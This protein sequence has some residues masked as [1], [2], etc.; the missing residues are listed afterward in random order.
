[1]KTSVLFLLFSFF[2]SIS[3]L[4]QDEFF[5]DEPAP[6]SLTT[7]VMEGDASFSNANSEFQITAS[8]GAVIRYDSGFDIPAG[9]T[10]RF[11]QPSVDATVINE[12]IQQTPSQIEGNILA[13]GKVVLLNSSGIV[14]GKDSV[15][16]WANCMRSG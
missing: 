8:D 7:K 2:C 15:V 16:R 6:F 3:A 10:V 5:D 4:A 1:M 11:I 12:I 13:N 14:F 9:E